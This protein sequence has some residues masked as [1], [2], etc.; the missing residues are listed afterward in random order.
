MQENYKAVGKRKTSIAKVYLKSGSGK[1]NV[2]TK[3]LKEY[4][5]SQ[6]GE[7]E[8]IK[9]PLILLSLLQTYDLEI[10]VKGGGI[11]AQIDAIRLAISRALSKIKPEYRSTLKSNFLLNRDARIK[12]RR[13]YGLRKARKAPQFSKR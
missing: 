12:E 2:N 5:A 4:F 11:C 8:K 6:C 9:S 3:E 7:E 1:I 10:F 13:K